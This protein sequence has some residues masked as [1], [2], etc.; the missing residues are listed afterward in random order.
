M[1]SI[2]II[3]CN[4]RGGPRPSSYLVNVRGWAIG[5]NS[6]VAVRL[7]Q[8]NLVAGNLEGRYFM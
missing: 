4:G 8:P 2:M 6:V 1:R 3:P 7:A 5:K